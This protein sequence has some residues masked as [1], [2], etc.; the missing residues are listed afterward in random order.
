MRAWS[1]IDF[2]SSLPK[3]LLVAFRRLTVSLIVAR[4]ALACAGCSLF[5][6]KPAPAT[7]PTAQQLQSY[8]EQQTALRNDAS[9][10]Q[11]EHCD[12]LVA[13]TPGVEEIRL[14]QGAVESRQWTLIANGANWRWVFV[15]TTDGSPE[16][17]AP[18]PGIDKLNFEPRLEPTLSTGANVFLAYASVDPQNPADSPRSAALRDT[19]GTP[20]GGFTWRGRRYAYALTPELPCFPRLQ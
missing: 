20:Q 4:V 10:P 17:W 14:H 1:A 5:S 18:K 15:R 12:E 9:R 6:D 16:G 3:T 11:N 7:P 13:A 8:A 19:F 2:D